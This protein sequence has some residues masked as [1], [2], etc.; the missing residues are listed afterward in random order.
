MKDVGVSIS[1]SSDNIGHLM[2]VLG[3]LKDLLLAKR[4]NKHY[5][6]RQIFSSR[7]SKIMRNCRII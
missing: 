5:E 2:C 3:I 4:R 1:I 7:T 6:D